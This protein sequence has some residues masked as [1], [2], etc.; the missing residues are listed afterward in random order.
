MV[1]DDDTRIDF[2]ICRSESRCPLPLFAQGP[3]NNILR[4][5]QLL[6]QVRWLNSRSKGAFL[7]NPM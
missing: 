2:V 7:M 4:R 5:K 3:N 1:D 6:D